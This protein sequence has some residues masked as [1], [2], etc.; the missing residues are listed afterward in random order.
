MYFAGQPWHFTADD[1]VLTY[2]E[3]D[4][5]THFFKLDGTALAKFE[6]QFWSLATDAQW[7]VAYSEGDIGHLATLTPE[8]WLRMPM[9]PDLYHSFHGTKAPVLR[10]GQQ[11]ARRTTELVES[12]V[13]SGILLSDSLTGGA[14]CLGPWH[15]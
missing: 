12:Y 3:A 5:T 10:M 2:S 8:G 15:T 9:M 4:D 7:L 13:K 1:E 11:I 14:F 6:G